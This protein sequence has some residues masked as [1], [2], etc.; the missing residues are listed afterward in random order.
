MRHFKRTTLSLAAVQAMVWA[1]A[2]A[3][4]QTT[5]APAAATS[6]AAKDGAKDKNPQTLEAVVVSGR[7]A[8]L[9]TAQKIKQ[10][11]DEIV[12]SVVAEEI[13]KLPDRSVTEVL[14]RVVGVAM[15]RVSASNDPVHFSAEGSGV[16]IRGLTY[17][18]STL[19]GRETFSAN[20]GR[21]LGFEDV[22]PELMAVS[23]NFR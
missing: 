10:D 9:A 11:S 12:D 7:R 8:A 18:S 16:I 4:A 20:Q 1:A 17:V 15:D 2:P 19:N 21:T 5:P 13:G 14:Q 22:P 23:V 6:P 3:L